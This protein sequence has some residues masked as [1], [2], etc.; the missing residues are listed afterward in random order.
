M[1]RRLFTLLSAL[2]LLLCA[3]V[4]VLLM[5]SHARLDA[6]VYGSSGGRLVELLSYRGRVCVRVSHPW[7]NDQPLRWHSASYEGSGIGFVVVGDAS[8]ETTGGGFGVETST[9]LSTPYVGDDGTVPWQAH[10]FPR[11]MEPPGTPGRTP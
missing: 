5:R 3:A 9:I 6:L 10:W 11:A 4:A 7:P 8:S 2:S 1:A